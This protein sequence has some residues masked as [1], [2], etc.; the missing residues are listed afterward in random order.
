M[1]D[2]LP[3]FAL[4]IVAELLLQHN[5]D[6]WLREVE[7]GEL[8]PDALLGDERLH[9]RP[10]GRRRLQIAIVGYAQD[11]FADALLGQFV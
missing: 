5:G 6:L 4:R 10:R 8:T 7:L 9:Q 3:V 1:E 11:D 2:L